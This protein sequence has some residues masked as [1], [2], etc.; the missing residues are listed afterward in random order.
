MYRSGF[1]LSWI[2]YG[3]M[4][5]IKACAVCGVLIHVLLVDRKKLRKQKRVTQSIHASVSR[6]IILF[7]V[8]SHANTAQGNIALE[9]LRKNK[10][11]A[12]NRGIETH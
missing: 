5:I 4:A 6:S 2:N 10:C 1:Q 12:N 7:C 8:L 11:K 9:W 3:G